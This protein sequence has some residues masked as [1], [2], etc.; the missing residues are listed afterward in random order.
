MG[1]S[2]WS[3]NSCRILDAGHVPGILTLGRSIGEDPQGSL[4]SQ[5]S[6]LECSR[7]SEKCCL[8]N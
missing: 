3:K 2:W 6:Q 7:F 4:A 1:V 5:S 8:K